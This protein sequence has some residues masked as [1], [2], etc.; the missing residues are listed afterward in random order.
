MNT[1]VTAFNNLRIARNSCKYWHSNWNF[2]RTGAPFPI[3]S[4]FQYNQS[5]SSVVSNWYN[6]IFLWNFEF[7]V[8]FYTRRLNHSQKWVETYR[9]G[10]NR[11]S[12]Q[13]WIYFSKNKIFVPQK[14]IF[15]DRK[16]YDLSALR[17]T[18]Y[19]WNLA[20]TG[21]CH[22]YKL[23]SKWLVKLFWKNLHFFL[24]FLQFFV[25]YVFTASPNFCFSSFS[26]QLVFQVI[27]F[28]TITTD[29]SPKQKIAGQ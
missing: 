14:L 4:V 24:M 8:I 21:E 19:Q 1:C 16:K 13:H 29:Q 22:I 27:V 3:H 17:V 7:I 26:I 2:W 11:N 25:V 20:G 10:W 6:I 5:E 23:V 12:F 9:M 15:L 18:K 28:S